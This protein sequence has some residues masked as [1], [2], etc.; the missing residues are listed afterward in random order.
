[1][2]FIIFYTVLCTYLCILKRNLYFQ[3]DIK[4]VKRYV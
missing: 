3:P 4:R 1:M 2:T